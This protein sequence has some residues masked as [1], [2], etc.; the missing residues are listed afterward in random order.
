MS[1]HIPTHMSIQL[2]G[3]MPVHMSAHMQCTC[4]HTWLHTRLYTLL[5]LLEHSEMPLPEHRRAVPRRKSA[6][7]FY[8][9]QFFLADHRGAC[10]RGER[11]KGSWLRPVRLQSSQHAQQLPVALRRPHRTAPRWPW[12]SACTVCGGGSDGGEGRRTILVK[13]MLPTPSFKKKT[14]EQRGETLIPNQNVTDVLLLIPNPTTKLT[15]EYD[16]GLIRSNN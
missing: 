8:F 10:R 12:R 15:N 16:T 1:I 3:Q 7:L 5:R 2:S 11:P 9:L 14:C 6:E 4:L 13:P